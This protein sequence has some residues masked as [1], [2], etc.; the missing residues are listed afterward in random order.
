MNRLVETIQMSSRY[1]GFG[2]EIKKLAYLKRT[3]SGA[4][5]VWKMI[6]KDAVEIKFTLE[7]KR[8]VIY[9]IIHMNN[10]YLWYLFS[11]FQACLPILITV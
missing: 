5:G 10:N 11:E 4:L 2:K 1:I 6:I 9:S 3:L 7:L 8:K